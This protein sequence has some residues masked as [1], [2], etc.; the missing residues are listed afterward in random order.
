[1]RRVETLM[2]HCW[3]KWATYPVFSISAFWFVGIWVQMY[4]AIKGNFTWRN[5][6]ARCMERNLHVDHH[7]KFYTLLRH[8]VQSSTTGSRDWGAHMYW[9]K[10]WPQALFSLLL[11]SL[12]SS[13]WSH[14]R[15][16]AFT[17]ASTHSLWTPHR[18]TELRYAKMWNKWCFNLLLD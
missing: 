17:H 13:Y 4:P 9:P 3:Q 15:S 7:S 10:Y 8:L 11:V 1:M 5:W 2:P 16:S 6:S 12:E 18:K 14:G